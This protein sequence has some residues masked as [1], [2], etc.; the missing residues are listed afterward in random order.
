MIIYK[1]AP[2]VVE[3]IMP[4]V[5]GQQQ[6]IMF[7]GRCSVEA[8]SLYTEHSDCCEFSIPWGKDGLKVYR[9]AA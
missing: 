3:G 5:Y 6:R 8:M 1:I 7:D 2:F 4:G 9:I